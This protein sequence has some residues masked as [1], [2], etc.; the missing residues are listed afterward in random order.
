MF[1]QKTAYEMRISD[2]SS[3]VCSSDLTGE[4]EDASRAI[5]ML[6]A[7]GVGARRIQ[8]YVMIGHEPFAKCMERIRRVIDLGGEPYVK[9]VMKLNAL[10]KKHWVPHDWTPQKLNQVQRWVTRRVRR[11]DSGAGNEGVRR[12]KSG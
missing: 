7:H 4:L 8:V 1:K 5:R 12:C 2:W 10:T 11:A 9:P 6:R 3:D